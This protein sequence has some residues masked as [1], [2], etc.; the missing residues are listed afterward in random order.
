M[1]NPGMPNQND[2][3]I[4]NALDFLTKPVAQRMAYNTF[5][6]QFLPFFDLNGIEK[7][8]VDEMLADMSAR[9]GQHH[10]EKDLFGNLLSRWTEFVSSPYKNTEIVN[11]EGVIVYVVPPILDNTHETPVDADPE[12]LARL[13]EQAS[14]QE[15]IHPKLADR[16]IEKHIAPLV[17]PPVLN[18]EHIRMWNKIFDY[19]GMRKYPL[20]DD[21][22]TNGTNN[23]PVDNDDESVSMLDYDD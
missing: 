13:V 15:K 11:E 23:T 1:T 2:D 16:Y 12:K 4:S 17:R 22:S 20:D 7:E 6:T 5:F 18:I 3:K 8:I 21:P 14:N 9:T 10:T 19:H